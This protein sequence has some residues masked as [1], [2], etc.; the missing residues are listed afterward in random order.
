MRN[1]TPLKQEQAAFAACSL[2]AASRSLPAYIRFLEY[3]GAE[4]AFAERYV[5]SVLKLFAFT[6]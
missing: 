3:E 4:A 5:R 2:I 6:P 1:N